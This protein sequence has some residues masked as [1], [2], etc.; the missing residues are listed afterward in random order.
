MNNEVSTVVADG[1]RGLVL[2]TFADF[3]SFGAYAAKS[4]FAPKDMR[5]KPEDCTL[6]IILGAEIGLGPMAAL[7]GIAVINGRPSAWGDALIAVVKAS[8]VCEYVEETI[9]GEGDNMVATCRAKRRGYPEPTVH[10]FAVAD[11]KK[12]KLW[13]KEGPWTQ[14]PRRMLQMRARGF[15]LRDAFPDLLRGVISREEAE[16]Y[17]AEPQPRQ[18]PRATTRKIGKDAPVTVVDAVPHGP[19]ADDETV[20]AATILEKALVAVANA[21]TADDLKDFRDRAD[22]YLIERKITK[23]E[24]DGIC[25]AIDERADYLRTVKTIG[26]NDGKT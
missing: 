10:H 6:A 5:G 1:P 21:D 4:Q 12:A 15:A 14:Y 9:E 17:P 23:E 20:P 2:E 7:Q 3:V 19:K 24:H 13:G 16:D 25:T 26:G 18:T 22:A 11:A 8:P